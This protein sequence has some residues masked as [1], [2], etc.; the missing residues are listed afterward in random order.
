MNS[1]LEEGAS[2]KADK[3]AAVSYL[4]ARAE[5]LSC[6]MAGHWTSKLYVLAAQDAKQLAQVL[7]MLAQIDLN[8]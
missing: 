7:D 2:R 1:P 6:D 5:E 4:N 3:K 8:S